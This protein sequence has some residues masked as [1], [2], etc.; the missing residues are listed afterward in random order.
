MLSN[1]DLRD[2]HSSNKRLPK[3]FNAT[4]LPHNF[5][6]R[7]TIRLVRDSYLASKRQTNSDDDLDTIQH[8]YRPCLRC[9]L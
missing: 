6:Y 5:R 9:I 4:D 3:L 2:T 7:L 1:F 8:S